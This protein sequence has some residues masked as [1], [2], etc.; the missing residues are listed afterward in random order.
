M[1][2]RQ[3]RR[4]VRKVQYLPVCLRASILP[5]LLGPTHTP[6]PRTQVQRLL[7]HGAAL[8]CSRESVSERQRQG[9]RER[10]KWS[11]RHPS[12][13][14]RAILSPQPL[15][16][17]ALTVLFGLD[18][19]LA[20]TF[21]YQPAQVQRLLT[22]TAGLRAK[23]LRARKDLDLPLCFIAWFLASLLGPSSKLYRGRGRRSNAPPTSG[24]LHA[25]PAPA[26]TACASGKG[27]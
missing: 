13:L 26:T 7:T 6:Q 9:E 3:N 15:P 23:G 19:L 20:L 24:R 16:H 17:M 2:S 11:E 10:E 21:L 4:Q 25:P 18:C 1:S 5:S 12:L 8:A 27:S 22:D 14:A